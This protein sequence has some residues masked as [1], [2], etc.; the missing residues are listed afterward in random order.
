MHRYTRGEGLFHGAVIAEHGQGEQAFF[1]ALGLLH[2]VADQR[3]G[4]VVQHQEVG[5]LAGQEVAQ[6]VVQ[7]QRIGAAQGGQVQRLER[8]ELLALQ[9]HH[10]VRLVQRLQLA[11]AGAGA[12]IGTQ[13]DAHAM[14]FQLVQVEQAAAEEQVG[15]RAEGHGRAGFGEALALVVAQVHA[16]GEHRARA[17]QLVVVVDIEIAL[18][19]GEQ[20]LD[21]LDLLAV[22]GQVGVH[23]QVR[24]LA[25]QLAGQLQLLRRAGGG[26]ARGDRIVQAALAVPALDQRL[27]L[28]VAGF[29]GVGQVVRGVAIH[30][31]LTGDHAQV[32]LVGLLEEGVH[33]LRVHAAEHQGGG[34]AVAQQFLEEDRRHVAG[35][36]L[37]FEL[38]LGGE[39]VGVE[40][41]QQLLAVGGDHAGLRVVDMGVDEAG[42]DQRVAVVLDVD[43][44]QLG[45]QLGSRADLSDLAVFDQQDAVLEILIGLL[46]T[47]HGRVGEAVQDGGAVGFDVGGHLLRLDWGRQ[48]VGCAVRTMGNAVLLVRAA[49]PT[50]RAAN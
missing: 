25:Q 4:V 26:K 36:S 24:V 47:D 38:P 16:M 7:V 35:V 2:A 37:V 50:G 28:G 43:A 19:L 29:G 17:D 49:H 11:E 9:L 42:G 34:S 48:C 5:V 1:Q 23:I 40:P 27:A 13:P 30:Q 12:D 20:F 14:G 3:R 41:V 46:D 6:L 21:P 22:L 10:L 33:R 8:V 32:E 31:H 44:G 45:Q 15:G 39:G 18:A